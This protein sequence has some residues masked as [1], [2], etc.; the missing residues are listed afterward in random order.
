MDIDKCRNYLDGT[1][2]LFIMVGTEPY[3]HHPPAENH[4][5]VSFVTQ[6]TVGSVDDRTRVWQQRV[7][8]N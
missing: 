3:P 6:G 1:G 7:R 4:C 8:L 5:P 2:E